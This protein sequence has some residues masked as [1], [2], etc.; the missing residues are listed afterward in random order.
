MGSLSQRGEIEGVLVRHL[1]PHSDDRGWLVEVFRADELE[2]ESMPVMG[3]V[4]VTRPGVARG[5]HEH[6]AQ[7]DMFCFVGPGEFELQLWDNRP[8]SPT[9]GISQALVVGDHSPTLI[10]VPPGVVHAYRNI[11]KTDGMIINFSNRLYKGEKRREPVDEIR[12]EED[13]DSPFRLEWG[14]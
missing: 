14:S 10:V 11:G 12:H 4:S 2:P 13:P 1:D 7:T 8:D 9:C 5:P 6:V 3:Y